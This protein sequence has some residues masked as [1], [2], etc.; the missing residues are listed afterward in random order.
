MR[1]A[2]FLIDSL[3]AT[4]GGPP[5]S[6]MGLAHS[7]A[8]RGIS[9]TVATMSSRTRLFGSCTTSKGS[10][11]VIEY[12]SLRIGRRAFSLQYLGGVVKAARS[13]DVI[14]LHCF[15]LWHVVV[16]FVAAKVHKKRLALLPH[17][18]FEPW[19]RK[20]SPLPKC[21]FDMFVGKRVLKAISTVVTASESEAIGVREVIDP[22]KVHV[23]GYG[24]NAIA[25][26]PR[27]APHTPIRIL[28][29]SR[30]A[31]KK[32]I[33]VTIEA[34]RILV[35]KGIDAKLAIA[36]N[37]EQS[38]ED[39]LKQLVGTLGL[40][41]HVSFTGHLEGDAKTQAL[42]EADVFVLPSESENY[43]MAVAEA[44]AA[45]LPTV[46]TA[47][48]AVS[49]LMTKH[50]MMPITDPD[51]IQLAERIAELTA[52]DNYAFDSALALHIADA[53]LGWPA[54]AQRWVD[55]MSSHQSRCM[56]TKG[57]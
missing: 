40:D 57:M 38:L 23:M 45:G 53:E 12:P 52:G 14:Q 28:S 36:G 1:Q 8:D 48:V 5:L 47:N 18:I 49:E 15:Y 55:A 25:D 37:G 17:G 56:T 46:V 42:A 33:D 22:D 50:G 3:D 24:V 31:P 54:S 13:A 35:D 26:T 10:V 34:V 27:P 41:D 21:L 16:G 43:S 51:P 32:R 2:L 4:H 19:Q 11:T 20:Q 9:I 30:L 39:S 7:L 29:M 44:L 6:T